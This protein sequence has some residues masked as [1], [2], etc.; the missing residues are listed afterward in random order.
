M[1]KAYGVLGPWEPASNVFIYSLVCGGFLGLITIIIIK[2]IIV[3]KII[4]IY[5]NRKKL[6]LQRLYP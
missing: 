1:G 4:I 6:N 2:L 3:Y 5:L